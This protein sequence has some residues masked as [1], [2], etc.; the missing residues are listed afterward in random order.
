MSK[1]NVSAAQTLSLLF[2]SSFPFPCLLPVLYIWHFTAGEGE[3]APSPW[4][5]A[6]ICTPPL[7][8]APLPSP[9]AS[10]PPP[11]RWDQGETS[12]G[13]NSSLRPRCSGR[14]VCV[15][16]KPAGATSPVTNHLTG[17]EE[18]GIQSCHVTKMLRDYK[19]AD[20]DM[21]DMLIKV[22]TVDWREITKDVVIFMY[23]Q[24]MTHSS[25]FPFSNLL[26]FK[27]KRKS[28]AAPPGENK[29]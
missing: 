24:F 22:S 16:S 20:P 27:R 21:L 12:L 25:F 13:W 15:H 6:K 14:G 23:F 1:S 18:Q 2:P 29:V 5:T 3:G 19:D 10:L 26:S 17:P 8:L 4:G 28:K 11:W 7:G 9:S